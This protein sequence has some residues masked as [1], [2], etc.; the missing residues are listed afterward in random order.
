[1]ESFFSGLTSIPPLRPTFNVGAGLD[2]PCGAYFVGENG[3]S[4]L[5]GG[6]PA[7]MSIQGHLGGFL[8]TVALRL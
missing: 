3:E 4:I 8:L 5:S 1:M 2:I 7:I 6:M